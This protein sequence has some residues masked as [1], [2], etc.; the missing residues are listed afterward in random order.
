MPTRETTPEQQ[1]DAKRLKAIYQQW[2]KDSPKDKPKRTQ[3]DV[4]EALGKGQSTVAQTLNG[5][6]ALTVER[7]IRLANLFGCA[8][9]DF[10]PDLARLIGEPPSESPLATTP[11][12]GATTTTKIGQAVLN[13]GLAISDLAPARRKMIANA[14]A[15]I[16]E[17]GGEGCDD[18]AEALDDLGGSIQLAGTYG[19]AK[20]KPA[21]AIEE[22]WRQFRLELMRTAE[23][24]A[25]PVKQAKA[26][27]LLVL[28]DE[29]VRALAGTSKQQGT[30]HGNNSPAK[31]SR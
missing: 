18:T 2:V 10:S 31:P 29:F 17:K 4:A 24:R 27:D 20:A 26:A 5:K 30:R 16:I 21:E 15:E 12:T 7:A 22:E 13:I 23:D 14:A 1:E 8:V 6:L 19:D 25:N 28:W 11:S 9:A 3:Y